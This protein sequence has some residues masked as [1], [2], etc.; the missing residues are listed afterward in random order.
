MSGMGSIARAVVLG[1][2]IAIGFAACGGGTPEDHPGHG[3]VMKIDVEA[4][5]VTLDHG[6]I[7]GLMEAM[8]MT[9]EVA[10]GVSLDGIDPG[11]EVDFRVKYEGGVYTVTELRGPQP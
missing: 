7:P 3:V 5:Q 4:R 6:D 2:A 9:F 10:P 8:T 1:L 11:T